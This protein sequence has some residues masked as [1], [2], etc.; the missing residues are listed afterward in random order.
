MSPQPQEDQSH[1]YLGIAINH[2]LN[3]HQHLHPQLDRTL[4]Q[5]TQTTAHLASL[6]CIYTLPQTVASLHQGNLGPF[7]K[8]ECS[9]A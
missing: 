6:Y 5:L 4:D 2:L 8:R 7:R 1:C 9:N 3:L